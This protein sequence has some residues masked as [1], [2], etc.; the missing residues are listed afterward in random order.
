MKSLTTKVTAKCVTL[1][2]KVIRA[3]A[4]NNMSFCNLGIFQEL[5]TTYFLLLFNMKLISLN[6]IIPYEMAHFSL[7]IV[8]ADIQQKFCHKCQV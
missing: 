6:T 8:H 5:F 1:W 4:K 7:I 2:G 3:E